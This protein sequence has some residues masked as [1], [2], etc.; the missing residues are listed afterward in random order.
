MNS[1]PI[2]VGVPWRV[3]I[4]RTEK[5]Y[6]FV[7]LVGVVSGDSD[8]RRPLGTS[9]FPVVANLKISSIVFALPFGGLIC[10]K[11]YST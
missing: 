7:N 6:V 2:S 9:T 10:P 8:H 5:R 4:R 3:G 11:L 1:T